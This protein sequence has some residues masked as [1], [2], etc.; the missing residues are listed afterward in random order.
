MRFTF[1]EEKNSDSR[2]SN[3]NTLTQNNLQPGWITVSPSVRPLKKQIWGETDG[4]GSNKEHATAAEQ[5][6]HKKQFAW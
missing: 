3:H 4:I 6:A 5:M 2:D 1:R